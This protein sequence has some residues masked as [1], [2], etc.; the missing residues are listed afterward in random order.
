MSVDDP[1]EASVEILATQGF[2][3][4]KAYRDDLPGPR[5]SEPSR[6]SVC[7]AL[8]AKQVA[9]EG[10]RVAAPLASTLAAMQAI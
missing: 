4:V 6:V 2:A 10:Q 7:A 8:L 1:E 9:A 5:Q 3:L